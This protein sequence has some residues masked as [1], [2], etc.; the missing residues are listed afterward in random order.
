LYPLLTALPELL[1]SSR[2]H[3]GKAVVPVVGA[4]FLKEVLD[5]LDADNKN[6]RFAGVS[7]ALSRT[8]TGDRLLTA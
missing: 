8:R 7:Q 6:P 2:F 3:G 4:S 1:D 5:A